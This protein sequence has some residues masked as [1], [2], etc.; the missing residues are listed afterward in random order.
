MARLLGLAAGSILIV[1]AAAVWWPSNAALIGLIVAFVWAIGGAAWLDR[2][3]ARKEALA[4]AAAQ[5]IGAPLPP[6][7]E[8]FLATLDG[9]LDLPVEICSEIHDELSDHL[10]DSIASLEAE[11]LDRERATREALARLGRPEELA[12]QLRRAHQTTR[13]LLAGAGGGVFSAGVGVVQG[14][15]FGFA[16]FILVLIALSTVLKPALD[17]V[18]G[19]LL[20][21]DPEETG[22]A[23][24][25]VFGPVLAWVPAFVAGRRAVQA[26]A[27]ASHRTVRQVGWWW[28]AAGVLVIGYVV[29]FRLTVQ[30]NWLVVPAE[31]AIPVAFAAGALMKTGSKLPRI[32]VRTQVTVFG[33][34]LLVT[35]GA[36]AFATFSVGEGR[37]WGSSGAENLAYDRVAPEWPDARLSSD[38]VI[39]GQP[40]I[41]LSWQVDDPAVLAGFRDLRFEVWR[42]ENLPDAP[43]WVGVFVPDTRYSVPFATEPAVV[44]KGTLQFRFATSHVRNSR[45]LV[46]L[47]GVGSDGV[48]Y[49]L[50][51]PLSLTTVFSGTAW[52]W[53]TAAE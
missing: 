35:L 44:D 1:A 18:T 28:A 7:A 24:A 39:M 33:A 3:S 26:C 36:G 53:L 5:R 42:A 6:D 37:S 8:G 20:H 17:F 23:F 10:E 16:G 43:D 50:A 49:R 40:V 32:G 48:R 27:R 21:L 34:L 11:G 51:Y 13:R 29:L 4:N 30:Q 31:L 47:T 45:W 41:D 12:R 25:A 19:N 9:R 14:Y 15:V 46:F 52:D 38:G 22:P 2:R